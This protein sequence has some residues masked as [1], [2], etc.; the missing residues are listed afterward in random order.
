MVTLRKMA[1]SEKVPPH[2]RPPTIIDVANEAKV[3][4]MSVSRVIN[5]HPSVKA[6]TRAKDTEGD[7]QRPGYTPNDAARM[8]KG[9]TGRTMGFGL[10][11]IRPT[12]FQL[13]S[14]CAGGGHTP[15]LSDPCCHHWKKRGSRGRPA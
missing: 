7:R 12:F 6:S 3:G 5:N 1:K 15:R 13:L 2:G 8:L 4:V 9:R 14:C 10:S 11:P